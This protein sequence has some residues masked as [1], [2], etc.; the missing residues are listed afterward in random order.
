MKSADA[1]S[2]VNFEPEYLAS[3]MAM[4]EED[5]A[6]RSEEIVAFLR[7]GSCTVPVW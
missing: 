4:G 7:G 3:L 1:L 5:A 6:E 2:M